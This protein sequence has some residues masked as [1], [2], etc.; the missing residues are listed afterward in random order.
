MKVFPRRRAALPQSLSVSASASASTGMVLR[1]GGVA[2]FGAMM[3]MLKYA[4]AHGAVISDVLF[5]RNAFAFPIILLWVFHSGGFC[6]VRTGRAKAHV[7][8]AILGFAVMCCTFIALSL[9]PLAQATAIGFL[10]PI[11]A[12]IF[13]AILLKE[14]VRSHQ[15]L[16]LIIGFS[17]ILIIVQPSAAAANWW[18]LAIALMA[19][20]GTAAVSILLREIGKLESAIT[21]VFWF[22]LFATLVTAIPYFLWQAPLTQIAFWT[23][24]IAGLLGGLAQMM[25]TASVRYAPLAILSP[26]DYLQIIWAAAWA[27]FLFSQ[28]VTS[29]TLSGAALIIGSGFI[30]FHHSKGQRS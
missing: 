28:P 10:A 19:A 15:I 16:A 22:T 17:G 4:M 9:L 3:A 11:F 5:Y 1:I 8:R 30:S 2:A 6:A 12:T 13:A 25:I 29:A 7:L 14:R 18:G 26:F 20:I 24:V 23:L 27:Y 21:T